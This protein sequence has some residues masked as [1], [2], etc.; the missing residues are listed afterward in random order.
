MCKLPEETEQFPMVSIVIPVYNGSAYLREAIESALNQTYPNKEV[1]VVNDGSDDNGETERI[2][3]SY[4]NR[5]RYIAQ[6]NGGVSSA[7]NTGIQNMRGSYFS[8]LSHDDVYTPDKVKNQILSLRGKSQRTIALC[9]ARQIDK[10]SRFL[11]DR[12]SSMRNIPNVHY[13]RKQ[14]LRYMWKQGYFCGCALLIPRGVFEECGLFNEDLRYCQDIL[15]W[16]QIFLHEFD[17]VCSSHEDVYIRI[18]NGQLTQTGRAVYHGDSTR[19]ADIV[20]E[21]LA[22]SSDTEN[23]LLFY[24]ARSNAIYNNQNVVRSCIQKAEEN[25]LFSLLQKAQLRLLMRYG[26][27]RPFLRRI[28]YALFKNVRT[29]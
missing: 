15:M 5:I 7:L 6:K 14:A 23:N 1:I 4:G 13:D 25:N 28:F 24:Y 17:L 19:I 22:G 16:I 11:A 3:L 21:P 9:A 26:R 12:Y 10:N 2:A 27:I 20:L 8:W 29:Q 18:H